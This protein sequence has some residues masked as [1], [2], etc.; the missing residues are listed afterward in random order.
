LCN[1]SIWIKTIEPII[2]E[3]IDEGGKVRKAII[4]VHT[5]HTEHDPRSDKDKLFLPMHLVVLTMVKEN[6]KKIISTSKV[7]LASICDEE[8]FKA[9]VGDLERVRYRLSIIP[10]KVE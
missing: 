9:R 8:K 5:K 1:Y 7:A 10:K 6:L 2:N 3:S 4:F